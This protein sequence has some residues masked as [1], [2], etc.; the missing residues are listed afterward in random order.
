MWYTIHLEGYTVLDIINKDITTVTSGIVAHGT[1][2]QLAFGSGVAGAI[3]KKWPRV[4]AVF[5]DTKSANRL[6]NVT[7]VDVSPFLTVLNCYTQ[8]SYGYD[9]KKYADLGAVKN[10]LTTAFIL[11]E[12]KGLALHMPKIGC[13]LGGLEWS[14][15]EPIIEALMVEYPVEVNI[16]EI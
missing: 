12:H 1:N 4:Y 10:C 2:T 3:R 7:P 6:G 9:G 16:Y 13:G 14:D 15:V 11:A 8:D 5:M